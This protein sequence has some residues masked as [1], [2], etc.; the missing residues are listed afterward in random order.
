ML[1]FHSVRRLMNLVTPRLR[2][3]PFQAT[4]IDSTYLSWL[5]DPEVTRFSNQRFIEHT[6]HSC[7]AY[8]SNFEK[9]DNSFLLIE[10]PQDQRPIGTVTVYRKRQHGTAELGLM[11]G[12][13]CCWGKG[14]GREA[15][16]SV[17]MALFAKKGCVRLQEAPHVRTSRWHE[18]WNNRICILRPFV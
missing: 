4:D 8:L 12:E 18:S 14:Y 1:Q 6:A 17:L 2:L 7:A 15:W 3:R 16:Q 5:N 10:G 13:R 9:S 11:I